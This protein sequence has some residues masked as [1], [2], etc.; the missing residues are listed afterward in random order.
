MINSG[1]GEKLK[2]ENPDLVKVGVVVPT[3][4]ERQNYLLEALNSIRNAGT[5]FL[6]VVC[7]SEWKPSNEIQSLLD[8][9]VEDP[10][11]GLAAAINL[12]V[13]SM[14]QD[15]ELVT[16]LGDDDLLEA[17]ALDS[18][19]SV[20][21]SEA[22][23]SAVFGVCKFIDEF[24]VEFSRSRYGRLAVPLL[25]FGPDLIPQPASLF[26]REAFERIGGLNERLKLAFDLDLFIRLAQVGNVKFVPKVF[27]SYRWHE[28]SL[29]SSNKVASRLESRSVRTSHL[30]P[31]L[32]LLSPAWEIPMEFLAGAMNRM[33]RAASKQAE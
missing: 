10:G 8:S 31:L 15:V 4:G 24:A 12:A 23:L 16:W 3:L 6:V 9:R 18:M 22:N 32:R 27:A 14:P 11:R 1:H 25:K 17:G 26:S 30:P 5:V 2:K 7:P 19:R 29:S 20:L 33:D 28:S 21:E 13:R